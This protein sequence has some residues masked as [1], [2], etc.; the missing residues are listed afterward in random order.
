MLVTCMR[1]GACVVVLLRPIFNKH[2]LL[3]KNRKLLLQH[4]MMHQSRLKC[5]CQLPIIFF[6]SHL[7]I[8]PSLSMLLTTEINE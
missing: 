4:P 1:D 2:H 7:Y 6:K 8:Q 3:K 5:I